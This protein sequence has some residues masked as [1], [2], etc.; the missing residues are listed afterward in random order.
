MWGDDFEYE[1]K[2]LLSIHS[3]VAG[4]IVTH[5][6]ATLTPEEK[7]TLSKHYTENV[8]AYKFYLR[9]RSFWNAS[10][11]ENLDSAESNYKKAIELEPNYALAYAGLADCYTANYKG[12]SQLEQVPIAKIYVKKA[13]S[14]DSTLSE[15]L[16]TL[17]FIQQNF[18]YD[19]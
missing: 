15:G 14:L 11:R 4:E 6:K 7:K 2:E 19:W 8:E 12:L 3:R 5:L 13:L 10:G 1:A 17:G 9:G 16:T 18:D